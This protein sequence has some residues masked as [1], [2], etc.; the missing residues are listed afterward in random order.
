M[1]QNRIYKI[2]VFFLLLILIVA[3]CTLSQTD[4]KKTTS[5]KRKLKVTSNNN[6]IFKNLMID[7]QTTDGFVEEL[8]FEAT[9]DIVYI[10]DYPDNYV[11]D[12][13]R[14]L[15]ELNTSEPFNVSDLFNIGWS[16]KRIGYDNGCNESNI[17]HYQIGWQDTTITTPFG[18]GSWEG[19]GLLPGDS[20]Y[21]MVSIAY[22]KKSGTIR[23][24]DNS[25]FVSWPQYNVMVHPA[26]Y[27]CNTQYGGS[28][29]VQ[30]WLGNYGYTPIGFYTGWYNSNNQGY[31]TGAEI[32]YYKHGRGLPQELTPAGWLPLGAWYP[33]NNYQ[34][35][36]QFILINKTNKKIIT[37]NSGNSWWITCWNDNRNEQIP[38]YNLAL[39]FRVRSFWGD[40]WMRWD[41]AKANIESIVYKIQDKTLSKS[42]N[43]SAVY[44]IEA[45]PNVVANSNV[46]IN[47]EAGGQILLKDGV[48]I[49]NGAKFR[50]YINQNLL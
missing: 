6:G 4:D 28:T 32:G 29:R 30:L 5:S 38:W 12:V 3:S 37:C 16:I 42:A 35:D 26:P 1:K 14:S 44:R 43:Y 23:K 8:F 7:D 22:Y 2:T 24:F 48:H 27:N 40:N 11:E 47:F 17:L 45:G 39:Y 34:T 33:D 41:G 15:Q 25:K 20:Y 36:I 13:T 10:S 49:Y 21:H 46:N 31:Y 18:F 19:N 50:A 9:D